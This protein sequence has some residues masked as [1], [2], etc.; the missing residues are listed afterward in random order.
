MRV[1]FLQIFLFLLSFSFTFSS[2]P[3]ASPKKLRRK[4]FARKAAGS[5]TFVSDNNIED[6]HEQTGPTASSFRVA[7]QDVYLW[8]SLTEPEKTVI[9]QSFQQ[10]ARRTCIKFNELAYKPWYD[11]SRWEENKPYVVIRKSNKFAG[12][13]DNI[14]EDV[15][16]RS[17]LYITDT[18]LNNMEMGNSSRGMVMAQLLRF[19]GYREEHLRPDAASYLQPN[20]PGA[21][22][23]PQPMAQ[24]SN[25]QLQWPFDP[26]SVTIPSSVRKSHHLTIYCQARNDGDI[27]LGRG[28][29]Y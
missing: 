29:A 21:H 17:L 3:K 9:R 7:Q 15:N 1:F 18:A 13:S 22:L 28:L 16:K 11:A 20:V 10:I 14:I 4:C 23:T 24:Y 19:M 25:E 2:D 5:P 6:E 12:Y 27:G 8:P 26:E